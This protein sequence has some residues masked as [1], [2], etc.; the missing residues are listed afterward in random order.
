MSLPQ[1]VSSENGNN[2]NPTPSLSEKLDAVK[3]RLL[4]DRGCSAWPSVMGGGWARTHLQKELGSNRL[5]VTD[6]VL[7]VA[8]VAVLGHLEPV[9]LSS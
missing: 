5:V 3:D 8:A 2:Y 4:M 7:H 9:T 1:T 6:S